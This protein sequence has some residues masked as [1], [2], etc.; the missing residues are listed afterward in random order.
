[1]P[2]AVARHEAPQ[3]FSPGE[4]L[5]TERCLALLKAV[6][7]LPEQLLQTAHS[8]QVPCE[9]D[10]NRWRDL[11]D[12]LSIAVHGNLEGTFSH[13][14]SEWNTHVH[15]E[16][17]CSEAVRCLTE[18]LPRSKLF[19]K[20]VQE[21]VKAKLAF[22]TGFIDVL[23]A[24]AGTGYLTLAAALCD[25]RVRVTAVESNV[26]SAVALQK[27]INRFGLSEQVTVQCVNILDF[28]SPVKFD[29]IVSETFDRALR[30]ENFM[31]IAR[32]TAQYL[33]SDGVFIPERVEI[34]AKIQQAT[35]PSGWY[36]L[37]RSPG[38]PL[39]YCASSAKCSPVLAFETKQLPSLSEIPS[40]QVDC[41]T[42]K[43]SP[44]GVTRFWLEMSLVLGQNAR[45]NP[46][47]LKPNYSLI[48]AGLELTVPSRI[49]GRTGG[50]SFRYS[51]GKF[52]DGE[53]VL[54]NNVPEI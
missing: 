53:W 15:G 23:D 30:K 26:D 33:K 42:D 2:S 25:P 4:V 52:S 35:D 10:Q 40:I 22:T 29:I 27:V 19:F 7:E 41:S 18:D 17:P 5:R 1:M 48:T 50:Y 34:L 12:A 24:G 39:E 37:P 9:E 3:K 44:H 51:P 6:E 47:M 46:L 49:Q 31:G 45:M 36:W 11:G 54:K 14:N 43:F 20:A 21:Q 32:A 8:R 38:T 13:V 28:R 16:L